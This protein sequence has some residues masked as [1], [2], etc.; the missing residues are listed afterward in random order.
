MFKI[1][2]DGT[3]YNRSPIVSIAL[4]RTIFASRCYA[5]AACVVMRVC[6]SVCLSVTFVDSVE[7]NKHIFKTFS[8]S[9][10]QAIQVFH[11]KRQGNIPTG[12]P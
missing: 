8:P 12:A 6:L 11:T 5:S 2:E 7:K 4:F 1:I 9:G 3:V 10:S